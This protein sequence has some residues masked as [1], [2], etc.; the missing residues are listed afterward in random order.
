MG[1]I[2]NFLDGKSC[3]ISG[4][5]GFL[6]KVLVEKLLRDSQIDKIYLL[7]RPKKQ[8]SPNER[9]QRDIV[10]SPIF[11]RLKSE[12]GTEEFTQ[13]TKKLIPVAG[14]VSHEKL[15]LSPEDREMIME[16]VHIMIHCAATI[17]FRERLDKAIRLNVLGSLEMLELAKECRQL[18]SMVHVSTAYVNSNHKGWVDEKLYPWSEDPEELLSY[19]RTLEDPKIIEEETKRLLGTYPNTYTYTKCLTEFLLEKRRGNVPLSVIRPTIIGSSWEEPH[20]GWVDCVS[21]AGALYLVAGLGMMTVLPLNLSNIGDQVPVDFVSKSIIMIAVETAERSEEAHGDPISLKFFHCGTSATNPVRWRDASGTVMEYWTRNPPKRRIQDPHV[22][23]LENDMHFRAQFFLRYTLPRIAYEQFTKVVNTKHHVKQSERIAKLESRNKIFTESFRHF[24]KNEWIFNAKN[25]ETLISSFAVNPEDEEDLRKYG[26]DFGSIEWKEYLEYFCWGIRTFVLKE[27]CPKP[28]A[29]NNNLIKKDV[30]RGLFSDITWAY[31]AS[32]SASKFL[33]SRPHAHYKHTV[34]MSPAVQTAIRRIAEKDNV[35]VSDIEQ[36]ADKILERM[37]A[38]LR[39]PVVRIMGWFFRKVWRTIYKGIIIDEEGL[40]KLRQ[41]ATNT[42]TP[43]ILM[44]THRSYIDFLILSYIF[45]AYDLPIPHIAAGEDFLNIMIV[46]M[47]F[48]HSGAFFIRR[49]FGGDELYRV[50]FSEYVK[51]L[52]GDGYPLEFFTE[53]T[54]SRSGYVLHPKMGLLSIVTNTLFDGNVSDL[55]LVPIN[56]NYEKIIEGENYSHELMGRRK[57]PESFQGLIRASHILRLHFGR[58]SVSIGSPISV[59]EFMSSLPPEINLK[60][61]ESS[62]DRKVLTQ[63]LAYRVSYELNRLTVIMPTN[64]LAGILLTFR[65]GISR[66]QLI[67]KMEWLRDEI[68]ARDGNVAWDADWMKDG[69]T[70]EGIVNTAIEL[71]NSLVYERRKDMFEPNVN[72]HRSP[73]N[74]LHLGIYRNQ[75]THLF[76]P[77]GMVACAIASYGEQTAFKDGVTRNQLLDTAYFLADLLK[78]EFVQTETP[79]AKPDLNKAIDYMLHRGIL[80]Q[81]EDGEKMIAT[82]EGGGVIQPFTFLCN[83]FW[84]FIDSYWVGLLVL[85]TLYPCQTMLEPTVVHRMQWLAEKLYFENKIS[86]F[87]SCSSVTLKNCLRYFELS[88]VIVRSKQKDTLNRV[89]QLQED[90]QQDHSHIQNLIDKVGTAR[91]VP[92]TNHVRNGMIAG[93]HNVFSR[94]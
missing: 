65:G 22:H 59:K 45:F 23:F 83:M 63:K 80:C 12:L 79:N 1:R 9:L 34:R 29:S 91:K 51:Q 35:K 46:N 38:D 71:L 90:Y 3:F 54:R 28:N 18:A 57:T 14:D 42:K 24:T 70:T 50:I 72:D 17:D 20:R 86:Y 27:R 74:L 62:Q 93:F 11:H 26:F 6:A 67:A 89:V 69:E 30:R 10:D 56:I 32:P 85:S 13:L 16:N 64:M 66:D 88:K 94:L 43:V 31:S 21:A 7:I 19:I 53:G 82:Q 37:C 81:S 49:A 2:D 73:S 60:P 92:Q 5:T 36:R 58:I 39:M 41:V 8:F 47:I 61:S 78:C 84:P 15:G 87:E 52:I 33:K 25:L 44:P 68:G 48:R 76:F 40:E 55:N 4:S 75:M 77:E